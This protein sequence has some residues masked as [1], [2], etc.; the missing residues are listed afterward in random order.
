MKIKAIYSVLLVSILTCEF[1]GCKSASP[2]SKVANAIA[3]D[4]ETIAKAFATIDKSSAYLQSIKLTDKSG[5]D[6]WNMP[7]RLGLQYTSQYYVFLK[8]MDRKQTK[9]DVARLKDEI[10]KT[11]KADGSW[12]AVDD[13]NPRPDGSVI[14]A[15]FNG[16]IFNYW[17]LKIMS[18]DAI[19]RKKVDL[20]GFDFDLSAEFIRRHGGLEA[21]TTF[22]KYF[23]A[24][25]DQYDWEKFIPI[26]LYTFGALGRWLVINRFA[27][28]VIPHIKPIAYMSHFKI[29]Q[30]KGTNFDIGELRINKDTNSTPAEPSL[31]DALRLPEIKSIISAT[32]DVAMAVFNTPKYLVEDLLLNEQGPAGSWGAY[33]SSTMFTILVLED[34]KFR[35][36]RELRPGVATKIDQEVAKGYQFVETLFFT[37]AVHP[38]YDLKSAYYGIVDDGANWDTMLI[39]RALQEI[40][41]PQGDMKKVGRFLKSKLTPSGGIPFGYDFEAFPDT[42]DTAEAGIFLNS[43]GGYHEEVKNAESFLRKMQNSDGGWGAFDKNNVGNFIS[44]LG[45]SDVKDSADRFD[46]SSPDVTG[47]ILEFFGRLGYRTGDP[48]VDMATAYLRGARYPGTAVWD[49]RWGINIIYG[50]SAAV[51]GLHSIGIAESDPLVQGAANWILKVQNSDG[52]WGES[53]QSYETYETKKLSYDNRGRWQGQG[54]STASQTAWALSLLLDAGLGNRFSVRRGVDYLLSINHEGQWTDD[55]VTGT[56]HPGVVYMEYPAYPQAFALLTL[57]KYLRVQCGLKHGDPGRCKQLFDAGMHK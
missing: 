42:D 39:G 30:N 8:W 56:G 45:S 2:A 32:D 38:K 57:A 19:D 34:Y 37:P 5:A 24:L 22:T 28:W 4:E 17:A 12:Y 3:S 16:T 46:E 47:H 29:Q 53:T 14:A 49:G 51:T 44:K 1:S 21:S 36:R 48:T 11:R 33:T 41:Q 6:Y 26:P 10:I 15:D 31:L 52:G 7:S 35:M 25:F 18:R 20:S 50:T 43:I 13:H 23:L 9:L 54:I 40:G 55:S 27:Q